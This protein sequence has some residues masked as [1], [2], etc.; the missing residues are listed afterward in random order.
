MLSSAEHE[1]KFYNLGARSL[2][3]SSLYFAAEDAPVL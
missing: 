2:L 1:K 3:L